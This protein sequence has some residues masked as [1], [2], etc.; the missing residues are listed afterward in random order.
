MIFKGYLTCSLFSVPVAV[1]TAVDEREVGFRQVCAEH[2]EPITYRRWCIKGS[3]EVPYEQIHKEYDGNLFSPSEMKELKVENDKNLKI[4]AFVDAS[5]IEPNL[6][7]KP[8]YLLPQ[9]EKKTTEAIALKA[10]S[11]MVATLKKAKKV[12]VTRVVLR[13]REVLGVVRPLGDALALNLLYFPSELKIV[14]TEFEVKPELSEKELELTDNLVKAMSKSFKEVDKTDRNME[15]L[16]R[17]IEAKR[18]GKV[19]AVEE[20]IVTDADNLAEVLTGALNQ[21]EAKK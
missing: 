10:Y 14:P 4:E 12:G 13:S 2:K 7:H 21:V 11:L 6:Y 16:G 1:E 15:R 8:Y 3:H 17:M 20:P 9:I 19:I 18:T 5:E